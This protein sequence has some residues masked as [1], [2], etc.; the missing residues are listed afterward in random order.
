[1]GFHAVKCP[2]VGPSTSLLA[3]TASPHI[4]LIPPLIPVAPQYILGEPGAIRRQ[5]DG[6]GKMPVHQ[7]PAL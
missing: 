6:P 4:D 1:M 2:F 7:R 3:L 5:K